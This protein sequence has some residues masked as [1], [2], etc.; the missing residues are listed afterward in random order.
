MSERRASVRRAYTLFVVGV[1]LI[2][3]GSTLGALV[4]SLF[5]GMSWAEALLGVLGG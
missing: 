1:I 4:G 3:L 5:L 2:L